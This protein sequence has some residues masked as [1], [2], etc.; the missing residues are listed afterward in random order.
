MGL[1]KQMMMEHDDRGFGYIDGAMCLDHIVD[2][3]L[4]LCLE[5]D[6]NTCIICGRTERETGDA[7]AVSLE[8]IAI[9]VMDAVKQDFWLDTDNRYPT[10][11]TA[12]VIWHVAAG[13]FHPEYEEQVLDALISQIDN[14]AEWT[15]GSGEALDGFISRWERFAH[16]VKHEVRSGFAVA[17]VAAYVRHGLTP[18]QIVATYLDELRIYVDGTLD[19]VRV[20]PAGASFFRGRPMAQLGEVPS[21]AKDLGPA[22]ADKA[23]ANRMSAQGIPHFY[24]AEDAETVAAEIGS[25]DPKPLALIGEFKTTRELR[26]LDLPGKPYI[27]SIF[28]RERRGERDSALWLREFVKLITQPVIPDGRERV[29]YAPTQVVTEYL[30]WVPDVRID[31]IAF[32]SAQSDSGKKTYVLFFGPEDVAPADPDAEPT[33]CEQKKESP[34]RLA[35]K[36][37]P[38]FTLAQK[39]ITLWKVERSYGAERLNEF[40]FPSS[41]R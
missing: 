36:S 11:D 18:P 15:D 31:G 10:H 23:A 22:S 21:T 9:E 7:F 33:N 4:Q 2:L 24:G 39:D 27:P 29:E 8:A 6:G 28:N 38:T 26:V 13:A 41:A 20:I 14:W 35:L 19:L 34:L 30:R 25:H 32:P 37:E 3:D 40:G 17:P 12:D 1:A 5:V 16:A